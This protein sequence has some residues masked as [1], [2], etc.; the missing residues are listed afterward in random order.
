M[1]S[2]SDELSGYQNWKKITTFLEENYDISGR[3]LRHFW[4]KITTFQW[5]LCSGE[6]WDLCCNS[7]EEISSGNHRF[8]GLVLHVSNEIRIGREIWHLR[9]GNMTFADG[10]YDIYG[11][12]IWHSNANS[13]RTKL[14]TADGQW[15]LHSTYLGEWKPV[16]QWNAA[17]YRCSVL[18]WIRRLC[19]IKRA[20]NKS[21]N[22]SVVSLAK[23]HLLCYLD[24]T[25]VKLQPETCLHVS[26]L[27]PG[28]ICGER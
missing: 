26:R 6:Q 17:C 27:I 12:E 24:C 15:D 11:R 25:G 10:K 3:R 19:S 22:D 4:K 16:T 8:A 7:L 2:A 20:D 5:E 21:S 1:N 13:W 23:L 14:T 28:G 18:S 9:T